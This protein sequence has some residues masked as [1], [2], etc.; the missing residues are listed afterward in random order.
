MH[1]WKKNGNTTATLC[2]SWHYC[3]YRQYQLQLR[4][5]DKLPSA[6][7]HG[8]SVTIYFIYRIYLHLTHNSQWYIK[9]T[10]TSLVLGVGRRWDKALWTTQ[11]WWHWP[12]ARW[13]RC[14][15]HNGPSSCNPDET[16][17][18][19]SGHQS[20]ARQCDLRL[21]HINSKHVVKFI[22]IKVLLWLKKLSSKMTNYIVM[23]QVRD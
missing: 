12:S 23:S 21:H 16:R 14:C 6:T 10:G 8:M 1:V 9:S 13:R 18:R 17:Q 20:L 7:L 4:S 3:L 19:C 2:S 5:R 11:I 15:R 22:H